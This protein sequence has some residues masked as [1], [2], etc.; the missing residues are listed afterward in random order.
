MAS[1]EPGLPS[2]VRPQPFRIDIPEPV[3]AD[4]RTRLD[5]VRPTSAS[6]DMGW[7]HGTSTAYLR[8]LIEHWRDAYDWRSHEARLNT[9]PQFITPVD[10]E[11][12]YFIHQ[13]ARRPHAMALLLL[14]GWPDSFDRFHRVLPRLDMF[15]VVVPSLPGFPFSGPLRHP[16]ARRPLRHTARLVWL[17]MSE[18]LGY[19]RFAVAGGDL[20]GMLAQCLAIEHPESVIGIHLTDVGWHVRPYLRMET[21]SP[22]SLAPA[23]N[24]SPAGLASLV[25]DHFHDWSNGDLEARFG[26][27]LLLTNIMLHW[28]TQSIGASML[29]NYADARSPSL[30]E[31]ARV[32]L[33]VAMALFPD[34]IGG[35]PRRS[36]AERSLNVERWNEMP[37]GGHFA[38]LEEPQLYADDIIDFF[39]SLAR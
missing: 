12:L 22:R 20:G 21:A 10:G 36:V 8:D 26:R 4:L 25:V 24:D 2:E 18:V 14:H 19:Q 17:L 37:R 34:D 30:R 23:L 29:G 38:P 27:D 6:D 3:L 7:S 11:R 1:E 28:V 13:R 32:D 15:D 31:D 33:P 16:V 5:R 35:I 9:V 39:Y